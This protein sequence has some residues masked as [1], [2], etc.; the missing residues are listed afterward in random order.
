MENSKK[1]KI[2]FLCTGNSCRSQM[3]EGWTRFLLGDKVEPYSA[4]VEAHG[5]NRFAMKVMREAGI[6]ISSQHS[7]VVEEVIDINFDFVITLCDNAKKRCPHF[8]YNAKLIHHG[9]E[10]PYNATGSQEEI[11]KVYRKIR[12]Q[13]KIYVEK[14]PDTLKN[15]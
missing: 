1:T 4:G 11:M 12:D 6:D 8:P 7:K 14:L 15:S 13:I 10:D 3:A 2:L 5:M 9:F